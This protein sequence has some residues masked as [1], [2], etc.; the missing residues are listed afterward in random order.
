MLVLSSKISGRSLLGWLLL[1]RIF[2]EIL[3]KEHEIPADF[4]Y[5]LL[6]QS[7]LGSAEIFCSGKGNSQFFITTSKYICIIIYIVQLRVV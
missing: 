3:L 5:M 7:T 2:L 1:M 6:L 4:F